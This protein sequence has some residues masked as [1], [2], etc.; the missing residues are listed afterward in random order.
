MQSARLALE[1]ATKPFDRMALERL[2]LETVTKPVD[3]SESEVLEK[4]KGKSPIFAFFLRSKSKS[5]N[6]E[7]LRLSNLPTFSKHDLNNLTITIEAG[8]PISKSRPIEAGVPVDVYM[9]QISEISVNTGRGGLSNK[10]L[11]RAI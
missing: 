9:L 6:K 10:G 3:D 5:K 1:N 2:A 11:Q 7:L 8:V 4:A